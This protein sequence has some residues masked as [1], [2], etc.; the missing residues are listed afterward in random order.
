M[1]LSN[2]CSTHGASIEYLEQ[3][4]KQKAAERGGFKEKIF[5]IE[6]EE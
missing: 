1:Y 2:A 4:R 6:V 5:L 3:L